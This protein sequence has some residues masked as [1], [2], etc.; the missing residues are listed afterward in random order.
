MRLLSLALTTLILLGCG[1]D[2]NLEIERYSVEKIPKLHVIGSGLTYFSPESSK[3]GEKF[4]YTVSD[5]GNAPSVLELRLKRKIAEIT[6]TIPIKLDTKLDLEGVSVS[7]NGLAWLAN[8]EGP[9]LIEFDPVE[10]RVLQVLSPGKGLPT[11][12]RSIQAGRGFEGV[13]VAGNTVYAILQSI[14]DINGK[15][16]RSAQF[17]RIIAIDTESNVTHTYAYPLGG[18]LPEERSEV[19]ISDLAWIAADRFLVI[20]SLRNND[21]VVVKNTIQEIRISD[22]T[23]ITEMR[24]EN[25]ELEFISEPEILFGRK[26]SNKGGL[27]RSV[28]KRM[29]LDLTQLGIGSDLVEGITVLPDLKTVVISTYGDTKKS[30]IWF[31]KLPESL[32]V[33]WNSRIGWLIGIIL[34]ISAVFWALWP[35]QEARAVYVSRVPEDDSTVIS[36]DEPNIK[37]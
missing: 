21:G 10:A 32:I 15:T 22:A 29:L 6:R 2:Q 36:N 17:I 13:A 9:S 16:K 31:V 30:E 26:L 1:R 4:F 5:G 34:M 25:S 11:I 7:N 35:Q 14:L 18:Y 24:Y 12:L 23:D 8:E 33:D 28:E 20:E 37:K 3:R 19:S 27:I